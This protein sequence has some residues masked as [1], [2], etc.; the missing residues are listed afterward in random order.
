MI[1]V[2]QIPSRERV[3]TRE[4][5][6]TPTRR[7]I[8]LS[9][10]ALATAPLAAKA[11]QASSSSS[12]AAPAKPGSPDVVAGIPVNY[13]E[14]RTGAYTLPDVLT[15]ADGSKITSA[16]AWFAKRRPEL[17]GLFET[18]QYGR[19]PGKPADLAFDVYEKD[20]PAF[21][22]KAK[23]KQVRIR[24]ARTGG[25][26]LNLAVYTP[27][28]ATGAVPALLAINFGSNAATVDDP[29]VT[30]GMVWS[31]KDHKR[32]PYVPGGRTFGHIDPTPLLDAGIGFAAFCYG[33][34]D[35]DD[36]NGLPDG[37]RA[38][39][40]KSGQ[41]TVA[42][43]EWGTISAWAWGISRV[44]DYFETDP[45]IDAKRVAIH[46]VSRLGKTVMWAGAHDT[47]VAATIASCSGEGG[48]ALSR[49]NYGETIAHLAAPTR[50]P[51][52]FAGNYAKYA[53]FPDMAPM[54]AHMLVALHAPRPL[55]L[56]TGSTDNWS[57]PKGEFLSAVAAGAVYKLLGKKDL[58]TDAWPAAKTPLWGDLNY[59]MHE[60]G[61]GTVPSDWDI[62][63]TFLKTHLLGA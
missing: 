20:V 49:R 38:L 57:D 30:P 24:F 53:G 46:G 60:G 8:L 55:L 13:D 28:A 43:D 31:A 4:D 35:P 19:M 27:A 39:Y 33:D 58:G 10:I 61:H 56:Q 32:I 22:G 59:Y 12:S 41:A 47:R 54:D 50:Y 48:A 51:Y 16:K 25:P 40:L 2:E 1:A 26:V 44:I 21:G 7:S 3:A 23:R 45:A 15:A 6:M 14:A 63:L 18:Q 37:V 29:G 5:A 34:V 42:P 17:V 52:Q 62:Y 36:L 9:S 11:Q